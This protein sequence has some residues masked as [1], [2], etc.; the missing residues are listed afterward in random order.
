[1]VS[2][3][4]FE[5]L[6][7]ITQKQC[8]PWCHKTLNLQRKRPWICKSIPSDKHAPIPTGNA[9]GNA[10]KK[11]GQEA[12]IKLYLY[13]GICRFWKFIV[14]I[15]QVRIR[16][17]W[18]VSC[19][20]CWALFPSVSTLDLNKTMKK[21]QPKLLC[22]LQTWLT[23]IIMCTTYDGHSQSPSFIEWSYLYS[24]DYKVWDTFRKAGSSCF[25]GTFLFGNWRS[26]R[27]FCC[28]IKR[29]YEFTKI[30]TFNTRPFVGQ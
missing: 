8:H 5:S 26:T 9:S 20:C 15:V 6:N 27:S 19:W 21:V 23:M 25:Q 3:R 7:L 22:I 10:V 28:L 1:M 24:F 30:E 16:A 14:K 13:W 18:C 2:L 4:K 29:R 12:V 11:S 17:V